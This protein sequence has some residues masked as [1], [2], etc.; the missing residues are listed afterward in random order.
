MLS[1]TM[2]MMTRMF[3]RQWKLL[4]HGDEIDSARG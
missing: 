3:S 2:M 4:N 1:P